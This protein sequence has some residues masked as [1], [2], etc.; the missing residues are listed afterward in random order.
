MRG[1]EGGLK[2]LSRYDDYKATT[3]NEYWK[4]GKIAT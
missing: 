3:K 4:N 1:V 2:D